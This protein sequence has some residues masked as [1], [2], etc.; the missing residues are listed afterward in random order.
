ME[1][2]DIYQLEDIQSRIDEL[3]KRSTK[4]PDATALL[5]EWDHTKHEVMDPAI[6]KKRR[7]QVKKAELD[8]VTGE[9]KT[10]ARYE[11]REVNRIALPLEQDVVNIHTAF[12]FGE[13][14]KLTCETEDKNEQSVFEILKAIIRRNKLKYHN[15][16]VMRSWLSETEVAEYWYK[17][18]DTTWWGRVLSKIK[19]II[20]G[21]NPTQKLRVSLWS[22]FRGDKL[23]PLFNAYN[24]LVAF[25]REYIV[26]DSDN[27][28]IQK[29]MVIDEK[30][31]TIYVHKSTWEVEKSGP[32]GFE[33]IPVVYMWR[34][35]PYCAKVKTIRARLETLL[36]NFADCLDYNFAP[37][38]VAD[39]AVEDIVNQ[40]TGSEIVQLENGAKLAYLSWQQSPDMAKLEFENLTERY[41]ALT[42]TPRISFENLK[43]V[44]SA[45]SGVSFKYAFMGAHMA[46]YNHAETVEEYLQRRVNF[47]IHAIGMIIPKY[48]EAC[49]LVDVETKIT[50]YMITN[51]KENI[52]AAAAAVGGGIASLREGVILAGITDR[53]DEE[54]KAIQDER[55]EASN[56]SIIDDEPSV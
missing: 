51:Q 48:K 39:G 14:P 34:E 35:E 40:G 41:Y 10:P 31:V 11:E 29:F 45:F 30:N 18:Q 53:V 2:K 4:L 20:K 37:K 56:R 5:R 50:P 15:K 38:L 8:P 28:E 21:T 42:N 3:K 32:H 55:K 43:G 1:L 47:L 52:E 54:V 26:K 49:E 9:V 17:D 36:S 16:R 25:S 6:R 22:P 19:F 23:Y 46:V 24:D 13:D 44:G 12:T 27:N 7:V 33:K